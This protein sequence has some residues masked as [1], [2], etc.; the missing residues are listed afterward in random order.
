MHV[1][2]LMLIPE[3]IDADV[4]GAG[5]TARCGVWRRPE[6]RRGMNP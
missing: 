5:L 6:V 2:W 1:I 3:F 4:F